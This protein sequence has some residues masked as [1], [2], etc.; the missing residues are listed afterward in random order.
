MSP[1]LRK[2]LKLLHSPAC[3][4]A[5]AHGVAAT[6]EHDDA[7][8]HDR[9]ATV[10]DV[11][12]NKGQFAVYARTRWPSARLICFEPLPAPRATLARV[13]AGHA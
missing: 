4:P 7:L 13:T 12:A 1:R 9:F 6:L 8:G 3:W 2:Y 11:G 10:I 5:L